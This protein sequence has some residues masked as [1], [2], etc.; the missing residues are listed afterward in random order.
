MTES[1]FARPGIWDDIARI[2]DSTVEN[3]MN[4]SA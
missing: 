1:T 2:V 4:N 3:H